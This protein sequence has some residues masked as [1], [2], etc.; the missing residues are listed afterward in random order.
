MPIVLF[1]HYLTSDEAQLSHS[2]CFY[3]EEYDI[4]TGKKYFGPREVCI[5]NNI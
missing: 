1:R 4:K 2:C 3:S 5:L